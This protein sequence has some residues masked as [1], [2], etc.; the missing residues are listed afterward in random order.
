M[1]SRVLAWGTGGA[2]LALV[3]GLWW[4]S[5][6]RVLEPAPTADLEAPLHRRGIHVNAWAAGS[7]RRSQELIEL[8]RRTELNTLVI[9]VKDATGYVSY[10]TSVAL[11]REI[12]AD[13]DVR[14][15][16]VRDLLTRMAEAGLWPV[17]RIVVFKDPLLARARPD[18]AVQGP[19]GGAWVDGK[20]DLW[21]NPWDVRTWDYH[22]AIAR[23]AVALGFR[24]IQWDYIRFPDRPAE[25]MASTVY[26]GAN[27]RARSAAVRGFLLHAREGLEDLGVPVTADVFGVTTTSTRDVGIGQVWE[28]FI[29]VVDAA[30]PMVYPSH[31]WEGS[32]GFQNPNAYPYEIVRRALTD[33]LRR[34]EPI[35]GAGKI[36]PWL[37]AFTLGAPP[38]GP[39][40]VRAQIQAV[41]D[42]GLHEWMLW[43]P[44]S[45]YAEA[46]LEPA[47]EAMSVADPEQLDPPGS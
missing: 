6:D 32:F 17:A 33:A 41:Y 16:D 47:A 3:F 37:Q 12:G 18:H 20:G 15:R 14:V 1:R 24:E 19:E 28:S 40:R 29:D 31:Y 8:A 13:R 10:P 43:N 35:E 4:G 26:P 45:V 36:V 7:A 34:T 21:V 25:E 23:E 46:A 42:V 38:Y 22:V 11:A 30:L 9:D 44:A 27:G 5:T 39:E 2:G